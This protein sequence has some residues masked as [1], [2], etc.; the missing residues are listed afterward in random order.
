MFLN[1]PE[2]NAFYPPD[3]LWGL[4]VLFWLT[5]L[6]EVEKQTFGRG[7]KGSQCMAR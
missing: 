7:V 2:Q 3:C 1:G 6:R 5:V 4:Q